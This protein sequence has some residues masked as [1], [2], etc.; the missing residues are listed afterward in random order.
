MLNGSGKSDNILRQLVTWNGES[1]KIWL[2]TRN[3]DQK[4]GNQDRLSKMLH[5]FWNPTLRQNVLSSG[6]ILFPNQKQPRTLPESTCLGFRCS[7]QNREMPFQLSTNLDYYDKGKHFFSQLIFPIWN[8]VWK[9][10]KK[11][12]ACQC[13]FFFTQLN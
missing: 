3:D 6:G 7:N 2:S 13:I 10:L 11:L 5:S 8:T 9:Y 4:T 12:K 1:V